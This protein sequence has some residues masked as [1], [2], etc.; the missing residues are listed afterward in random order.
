LCGSWR[1]PISLLCRVL[2]FADANPNTRS[3]SN[4][5]TCGY[6]ARRTDI[7]YP[8]KAIAEHGSYWSR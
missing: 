2:C 8:I 3:D 4:A 5:H 6:G 1:D 7:R